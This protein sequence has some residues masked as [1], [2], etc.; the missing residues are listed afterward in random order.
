MAKR[1]E[2]DPRQSVL[3]QLRSGTAPAGLRLPGRWD[4]SQSQFPGPVRLPPHVTADALNLRGHDDLV[5]LPAGLQ[6]Y[7]LLL[8]GTGVRRLP[9]DLRVQLRLDLTGCEHLE[10]LP[11]GLQVTALNLARCTNL[12]AL[13]EGL[14]VWSLD[15]TGCWAFQHWPESLRIRSGRLSLR[16]CT[17]LRELPPDLHRLSALNVRECPNLTRLPEG[18]VVTGWIDI[19]HSGLTTEDSLPAGLQRVQLRWG[20]VNI[21][22]RIA[23]HP[24]LLTVEEVLAERNA[25]RRRVLLD[26][27][28]YARLLLDARAEIRDTDQDPGGV[29]QLFRLPLP[30]DEDL[31]AMSC[32]CPSTGRQYIIRVPP[33][34]PTCRHAAAWI[35]GFDNP[36]DY[37]PLVET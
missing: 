34:T 32:H 5:E 23:F 36:D 4:L 8:G 7:E 26:R 31:V 11:A 1:A 28:G 35:A 10:L 19:A 27:Y 16:G 18:L 33:E 15:M 12:V 25:E 21:D 13:P 29:R 37:Q 3:D 22:R 17:A 6:A 14:D 9:D 2:T 30:G 24:E 20:G